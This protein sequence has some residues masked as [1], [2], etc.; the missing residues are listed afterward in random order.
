MKKSIAIFPIVFCLAALLGAQ[1]IRVT[2]PAGGENWCQNT[3]HVITWTATGTMA[4]TV[5]IVLMVATGTEVIVRSTENDGSF[6][7]RIPATLAAGS[8][9]MRVKTTDDAVMHTSPAFTVCAA[10]QVSAPAR[11]VQMNPASIT[12]TIAFPVTFRTIERRR[13]RHQ[14]NCLMTMGLDSVPESPTECKIG[15]LNRCVDGGPACADQCVSQ[16]FRAYPL[17]DVTRLR[18][19]IGKNVVR[20]TLS[21]R[22]KSSEAN[23]ACECCLQQAL[24]YSGAMGDWDIRPSEVRTIPAVIPGFDVR[25]DV[26]EMM[27]S[28][29][30]EESPAFH[31]EPHNYHMML[32]GNNEAMDFNNSKCLSIFDRG[33]LEIAYR[34]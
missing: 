6:P 5:K 18:T 20:A 26:T 9:R 8:Y 4:R 23:P 21:F 34:D 11:T 7:W 19:L 15:F 14:W 32:I 24:F 13:E 3:E 17:F 12:H 25:I 16:V 31:G 22:H 33:S 27:R 1:S 2:S 28:W 10:L 29:L 30:F